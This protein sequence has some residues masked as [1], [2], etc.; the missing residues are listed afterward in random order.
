VIGANEGVFVVP[1]EMAV[2]IAEKAKMRDRK[3]EETTNAKPRTWS[4]I[5]QETKSVSWIGE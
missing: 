1:L 4:R 5:S 2:A 3:E